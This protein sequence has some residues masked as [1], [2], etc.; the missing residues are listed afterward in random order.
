MATTAS[1]G[2][3]TLD[4]R[5]RRDD[6]ARAF[7]AEGRTGQPIFE[8]FVRQNRKP[9]HNVTEVKA[10]CRDGN[11]HLPRSGRSTLDRHPADAV[12]AG[13]LALFEPA[14]W[15]RPL[16]RRHGHGIARLQTHDPGGMRVEN[17][18]RL[19]RP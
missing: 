19:G 8:H 3:E 6:M 18:V 4:I 17:D 11:F 13:P 10:G 5:S 7:K 14:R 12:E 15:S 9:P 16:L 2:L 1:P